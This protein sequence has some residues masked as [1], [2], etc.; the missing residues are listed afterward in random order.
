MFLHKAESKSSRHLKWLL[1]A[2]TKFRDSS[3]RL[4]ETTTTA[5]AQDVRPPFASPDHLIQIPKRFRNAMQLLA[6]I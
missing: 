1:E 3:N 2:S 5:F 4:C 6:S